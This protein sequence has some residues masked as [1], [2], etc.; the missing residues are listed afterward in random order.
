M[1]GACPAD[2]KE[3]EGSLV[4]M[5]Q[6]HLVTKR[7]ESHIH[8]SYLMDVPALSLKTNLTYANVYCAR[9]HGDDQQLAEWDVSIN[10][11]E[12]YERSRAIASWT[13]S[14]TTCLFA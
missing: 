13:I 4:A 11:D 8:Y 7:R 14:V 6:R 10:C 3:G 1:I 12:D 5:C 9:C 2:F